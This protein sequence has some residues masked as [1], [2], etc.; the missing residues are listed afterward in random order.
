MSRIALGFGTFLGVVAFMI[1]PDPAPA[2]DAGVL[3]CTIKFGLSTWAVPGKKFEGSGVV[4][5]ENGATLRVRIVANGARLRY[6]TS[7][8]DDASGTFTGVHS[9]TEIL[10]TYTDADKERAATDEAQILSK[11][12]VM[13]ALT[14]GNENIDLG[15]GLGEFI[16]TRSQ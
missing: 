16:L 5:C 6:A 14:G 9:V 11:G 7:M 1:Y 13:L 10:G 8:V 15:A 2:G 12:S 4:D 3:G